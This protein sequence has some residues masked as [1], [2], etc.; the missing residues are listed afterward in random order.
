M[1]PA[2]LRVVRLAPGLLRVGER[3]GRAALARSRARRHGERPLLDGA[4]EG[5]FLVRV[6]QP[7]VAAAEEAIAVLAVGRPVSPLQRADGDAGVV[8]GRPRV[9]ALDE[10]D[11]VCEPLPLRTRAGREEV[12]VGL[13]RAELAEP[14]GCLRVARVARVTPGV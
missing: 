3:A 5:V 10:V 4:E 2:Y 8:G 11:H 6:R 1:R 9:A 13:A 14:D 12:A 7:R